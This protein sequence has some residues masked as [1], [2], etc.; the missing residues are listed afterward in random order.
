[1]EFSHAPFHWKP[2][3]CKIEP[4]ALSIDR[5]RHRSLKWFV[6]GDSNMGDEIAHLNQLIQIHNLPWT[7]EPTS[8]CRGG[9]KLGGLNIR[10]FFH[11]FQRAKTYND[12]NTVM[13]F[14]SGLHDYFWP[15]LRP[16]DATYEKTL[17]PV[18]DS[19]PKCLDAYSNHISEI[20]AMFRDFKGVKVF[21]L[22]TA[23][24]LKWGN[25]NVDWG[26]WKYE[27]SIHASRYALPYFNRRA[28]SILCKAGNWICID[29][30]AMTLPRPDAT[31]D[32]APHTPQGFVHWRRDIWP[33]VHDVLLEAMRGHFESVLQ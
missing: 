22:T 27:Q 7:I 3:D 11:V 12:S 2:T 21:R 32:D 28:S 33:E 23:A 8:L 18:D 5:L 31:Q 19:K 4:T 26:K 29:A 10:R 20:E 30:Y 24:W 1:M 9:G 25:V 14:N 6:F 13:Y 15:C 17:S 16:R